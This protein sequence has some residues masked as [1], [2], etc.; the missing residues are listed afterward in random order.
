MKLPGCAE[1]LP[2]SIPV[3]PPQLLVLLVR[4][5]L[6]RLVVRRVMAAWAALLVP[7]LL[8]LQLGL[9]WRPSLQQLKQRDGSSLLPVGGKHSRCSCS[10]QQPEM[11]REQPEV[12]QLPWSP[13]AGGAGHRLH[14]RLDG[15]RRA[16]ASAVKSDPP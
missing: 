15:D 9:E 7:V 10:S 4:P 8:R 2:L 5:L 13:W 16:W 11:R 6:Q 14:V 3:L 12:V 1:D